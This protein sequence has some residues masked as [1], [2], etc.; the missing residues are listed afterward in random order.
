M[1]VVVAGEYAVTDKGMFFSEEAIPILD[2][3][4]GN[5]EVFVVRPQDHAEVGEELP[6]AHYQTRKPVTISGGSVDVA[7]FG[8]VGHKIHSQ[9]LIN[10]Y[11]NTLKNVW[12]LIERLQTTLKRGV[13][14]LN[15]IAVMEANTSKRYL[16]DLQRRG[17]IRVIPTEEVDSIDRLVELSRSGELFLAKPL[18]SERAKGATIL[19][20]DAEGELEGLLEEYRR[21]EQMNG[22]LYNRVVSAQGIIVQPFIGDINTH[23]ERKVGVVD[24]KITLARVT[25]LA[26]GVEGPR[27]VAYGTQ[28]AVES[29]EYELGP[30]ER[31]LVERAYHALNDL[32]TREERLPAHFVRV[33]LIGPRNEPMISEIEAINPHIGVG[34]RW[35]SDEK[36]KH[37]LRQ[38]E[39]GLSRYH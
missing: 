12:A 38:L 10:G 39:K 1:R 37:H 6:T 35:F 16:L 15:P 34:E 5:H 7:Y 29:V 11:V 13:P 2:H 21:P 32:Y 17:D 36:I 25:R 4:S 26:N 19:T 20:P 18:I 14:T 24:G 33:D 22:T 9:G 27:I 30:E 28:D 31:R 8:V 23:G 3:F